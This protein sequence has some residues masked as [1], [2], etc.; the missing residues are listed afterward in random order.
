MSFQN[1]KKKEKEKENDNNNNE[2]INVSNF[3]RRSQS[4]TNIQFKK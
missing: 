4:T 3:K 1:M 2:N